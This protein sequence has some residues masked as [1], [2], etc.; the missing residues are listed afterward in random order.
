MDIFFEIHDGLER[1]GPGNNEATRRAFSQVRDLPVNPEILDVGC[2]PGIQT[3]E[4]SRLINGTGGQ[5]TA[6]DLHKQYLDALEKKIEEAGS[7]NISLDIQD[8]NDLPYEPATFDLIWS[9]GAIYI[10]GFENGLNQLKQFLRPGGHVV[11]SELSWIKDGAPAE[12][13]N[14]WDE[15]Y[16]A[17]KTV[18]RNIEIA[19]NCGYQL[20]GHFTLP[21]KGWFDDYYGPLEKRISE[22]ELKYAGDNDALSQL[23]QEKLEIDHYRNYSSFYGYEFYILKLV[24]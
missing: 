9:E 4:L 19:K 20:I 8:M 6:I 21:E 12:I 22:L 23:A 17:M 14:F 13:L 2:G 1:E 18:D 7:N 16:P 10:M 24:A 15:A 3:I 11:V 5:I